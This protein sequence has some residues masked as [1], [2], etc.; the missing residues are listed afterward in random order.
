MIESRPCIRDA[1]YLAR[2]AHV[3]IRCASSLQDHA[4]LPRESEAGATML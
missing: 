2:L 3:P 1:A 4:A